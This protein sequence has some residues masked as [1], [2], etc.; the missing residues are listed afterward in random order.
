MNKFH[1]DL[2]A[3]AAGIDATV[4]DAQRERL[5]A[6]L[7]ATPRVR[8][9]VGGGGSRVLGWASAATGLV[10]LALFIMLGNRSQ[11]AEQ[12][13]TVAG[14]DELPLAVPLQVETVDLTRPLQQELTNLQADVALARETIERELKRSF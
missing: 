2:K 11:E 12:P 4:D 6:R 14:G 10:A 9:D 1:E 7:Q 13:V 8:A 5:D 3:D